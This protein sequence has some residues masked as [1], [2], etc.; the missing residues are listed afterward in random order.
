[1][2]INKGGYYLIEEFS[3]YGITAVFTDKGS[4]NMSPEVLDAK[5]ANQNREK[6]LVMFGKS[7]KNVIS[8]KQVHEDKI[9]VI[10]EESR[11]DYLEGYDAFITKNTKSVILTKYADCLPIYFYDIENRV[12]AMAHSGWKGT[13]AG[14]G[15]KTLVKM[16]K[17]FGTNKEKVLIAFGIGMKGC[18]YEVGLD[19]Y[20]KFR[21]KFSPETIKKSFKIVGE[22]EKRIYFDNEEFNAEIMKKYGVLETNIIKSGLCTGCTGNFFSHRKEKEKSGRNAG[23]IFFNN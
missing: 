9:Y 19:V 14:I 3:K 4:G 18:C 8:G 22:T 1:M 7:D 10:P 5:E 13:L 2:F 16:E 15:L 17:E 21:K 12:I 20:D 6:L 11:G 23:M